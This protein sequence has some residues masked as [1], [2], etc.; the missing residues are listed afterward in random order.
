MRFLVFFVTLVTIVFSPR[1]L[2]CDCTGPGFYGA[3]ALSE[4]VI[5]VT[6]KKHDDFQ[7]QINDVMAQDTDLLDFKKTNPK[8]YA[9]LKKGFPVSMQAVVDQVIATKTKLPKNIK[10]WGHDGV[11]CDTTIESFPP[12]TKWVLGVSKRKDGN[13]YISGCG[14]FGVRVEKEKVVGYFNSKSLPS[15]KKES[16]KFKEFIQEIKRRRSVE[17]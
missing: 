7:S 10:I 13:L 3:G 15:K 4:N 8:E 1:L 5:A 11:S 9:K 6:I 14:E 17:R 12:N 16:A 2:A